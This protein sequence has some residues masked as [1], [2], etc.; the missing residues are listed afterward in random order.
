MILGLNPDGLFAEYAYWLDD[1]KN[2]VVGLAWPKS[3]LLLV[4]DNGQKSRIYSVDLNQAD[5]LA[6]TEWDSPEAGLELKPQVK[7]LPKKLLLEVS[8]DNPRGLALL[9]PTEIKGPARASA[10]E[11]G[12]TSVVSAGS[13]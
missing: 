13:T 5:D 4:Q 9:G 1:A 3:N 8:L 7:P 10:P 6:F 12:Q 2:R 11:P